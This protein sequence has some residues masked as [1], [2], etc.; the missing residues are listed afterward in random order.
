M[1]RGMTGWVLGAMLLG[2][3]VGLTLHAQVPDPA[4]RKAIDDGLGLLATIFLRAIR[5]IIAPMVFS[6]LL[7]GVGRIPHKADPARFT[8]FAP[9]VFVSLRASS[10]A[11]PKFN[12]SNPGTVAPPAPVGYGSST[13]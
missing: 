4:T 13:R 8:V 1:L 10:C 7:A 6:T 5:M 3:A 11:R 9:N 12:A 2:I